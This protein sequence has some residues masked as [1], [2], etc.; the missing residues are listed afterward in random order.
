MTRR[1]N[2]RLF[3]HGRDFLVSSAGVAIAAAGPINAAVVHRTRSIM[4]LLLPTI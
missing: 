1:I 2:D 4:L 3:R